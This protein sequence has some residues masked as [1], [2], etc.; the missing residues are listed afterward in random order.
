VI[1]TKT[2]DLVIARVFNAP[3]EAV[4]KAWTERDRLEKWWGPK[5]CSLSVVTLDLRPGGK[6]QPGH[7]IYGRFI[8]REI[9]APERIVFVSSFSDEK[10]GITRPPFPNI[11]DTF[12]LEILNTVTLAES[13]SKTSLTLRGGPVDPTEAEMQT[14]VGM[15]ASMQQGF[16]GTFDQLDAFLARA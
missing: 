5:G 13:G 7:P 4:W 6:F 9:V 1:A 11:R 14:Y 10:G 15:F 16:G 12:P 8:Y 3:R 2:E